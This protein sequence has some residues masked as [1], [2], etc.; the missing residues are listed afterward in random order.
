MLKA[1]PDATEP[2]TALFVSTFNFSISL[3]A[4][5]GGL[6]VDGI[7]TDSAMWLA[8][9]I[10]SLAAF[11]VLASKAIQLREFSTS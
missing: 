3:G 9:A 2:A 5:V 11:A 7:G 4:F 8:G 10:V 6:A 1:A